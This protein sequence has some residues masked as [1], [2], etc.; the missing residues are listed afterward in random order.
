MKPYF[1]TTNSPLRKCIGLRKSLILALLLFSAASQAHAQYVPNENFEPIW[2]ST[3]DEPVEGPDYSD[4]DGDQIVGWLENYLG[5]DGFN[6]DTDGDGM[7]DGWEFGFGL[8]P[9][10]A[11]DASGDADSDFITN[12]DE[13]LQSTAP[14]SWND[15]A[16]VMGTTADSG[17]AD[18]GETDSSE[19]QDASSE[20][21]DSDG[22]GLTD[23]QEAIFGTSPYLVDTDGGGLSDYEEL[24]DDDWR[25]TDPLNAADDMP[26]T[27]PIPADDGT[28]QA[29][30]DEAGGESSSDM[31]N[32][33][34]D[35]TE[36]AVISAIELGLLVVAAL[37]ATTPVGWVC[38]VVGCV[39]WGRSWGDEIGLA[40]DPHADDP[41]P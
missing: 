28:A 17:S 19:T 1:L 3:D 36:D 34:Y 9:N 4:V 32:Q 7:N 33:G 6:S 31:E 25:N 15:Y 37:T 22:D 38:V 8:N 20:A 5:T 11:S 27:P 35:S 26:T 23:A 18:M 21:Q 41:L 24:N 10:D 30:A 14:N 29:Q 39:L 12:I 2:L 16:T 40:P 13:Y